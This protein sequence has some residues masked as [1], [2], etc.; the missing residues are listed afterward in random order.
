MVTAHAAQSYLKTRPDVF[1]LFNFWFCM[2]AALPAN[3][4][5]NTGAYTE[6]PRIEVPEDG[7]RFSTSVWFSLL[8]LGLVPYNYANHHSAL[9]QTG[10]LQSVYPIFDFNVLNI[11]DGE[12]RSKDY[13]KLLGPVI[14][15]ILGTEQTSTSNPNFS[16]TIVNP[17][18]DRPKNKRKFT[19]SVIKKGEKKSLKSRSKHSSTLPNKGRKMLNKKRLR[20]Y[21]DPIEE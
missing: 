11:V 18:T 9:G 4:F 6:A 16:T 20:K 5:T 1:G 19:K 2:A 3:A 13:F 21:Y 7:I 14:R 12:H 15:S 17:V 8:D 10:S